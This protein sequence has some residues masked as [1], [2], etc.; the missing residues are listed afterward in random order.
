MR[1]SFVPYQP[2]KEIFENI[3]LVIL[4][5]RTRAAK[6]ADVALLNIFLKEIEVLDV[7]WIAKMEQLEEL[8]SD[9]GGLHPS[10]HPMYWLRSYLI[11]VLQMSFPE[12]GS[13]CYYKV[14]TF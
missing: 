14:L 6:D 13:Q 8:Y 4:G 3:Y 5:R 1:A 10:L 11:R 12:K 9:L 7:K 2:Q